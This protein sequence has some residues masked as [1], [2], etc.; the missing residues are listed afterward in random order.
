[1]VPI[2][3]E[4]KK[5]EKEKGPFG[6][7]IRVFWF[8]LGSMPYHDSFKRDK[9]LPICEVWRFK[10]FQSRWHPLIV[11]GEMSHHQTVKDK[12]LEIV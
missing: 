12:Y 11:I 2:F 6:D 3:G 5:W 9:P 10:S 7:L 4:Q 8:I 1:M